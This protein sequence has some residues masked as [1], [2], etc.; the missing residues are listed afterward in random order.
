MNIFNDLFSIIKQEIEH[1]SGAGDLPDGLDLTGV[2]VAK[3]EQLSRWK[4][5]MMGKIHAT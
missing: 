2:M 5:A 4:R 3:T 1:L